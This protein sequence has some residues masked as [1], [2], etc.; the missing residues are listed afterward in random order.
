MIKQELAVCQ[1]RPVKIFQR[2]SAVFPFRFRREGIYRR[3]GQDG[4]ELL[5]FGIRGKS[6]KG[7]EVELIEDFP[8]IGVRFHQAGYGAAGLP[9]LLVDRVSIRQ[10]ERLCNVRLLL[11]LAGAGLYPL[12][13]AEGREEVRSEERRVG[14]ECRL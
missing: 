13:P 10:V 6:R 12:G 14:K 8:V 3:F 4:Q 11:A 1:N 7:G 5:L 2:C 9:Q